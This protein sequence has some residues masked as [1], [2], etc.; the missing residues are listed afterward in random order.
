MKNG[1]EARIRQFACAGA[2]AL[3]GISAL[4]ATPNPNQAVRMYNRIAGVPPSAATLAQMIT[5]DP[6]SY[7]H[8]ELNWGPHASSFH[9]PVRSV[10]ALTEELA[11]FRFPVHLKSEFLWWLAGYRPLDACRYCRETPTSFR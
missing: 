3:I 2:A 11:G 8:L 4:A 9:L 6:V 1:M 10:N 5:M 7:T